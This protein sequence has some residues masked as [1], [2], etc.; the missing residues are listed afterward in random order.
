[1]QQSAVTSTPGLKSPSSAA[2]RT[3]TGERRRLEEACR[4]FEG[5]FLGEMLKSMQDSA[6]AARGALPLRRA[7]QIFRRQQAEELGQILAR[8]EPLGIARLMRQ[9]LERTA[10]AERGETHAD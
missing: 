1:M 10:E 7:E 5:F 2:D 3:D 6:L 4:S 8:Q 9:A